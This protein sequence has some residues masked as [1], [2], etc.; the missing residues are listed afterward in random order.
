MA[1]PEDA[2]E[3]PLVAGEQTVVLHGS[4]QRMA[5][6]AAHQAP[7]HL[8][9]AFSVLLL[10]GDRTLLQK[11]AASKYHFPGLWTNACCSHPTSTDVVAEAEA[12]LMFEVGVEAS[13]EVVGSFT[14]RA[15]DPASGLVEHE[16]DTVLVGRT[17]AAGDP[18]P[19]EVSELRWVSLAELDAELASHPEAFT[20]WLT[21]VLDCV[22]ARR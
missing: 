16:H 10:D 9:E 22:R 8:H 20:P 13:L 15:T 3:P 14:Y 12:R 7:G 19:D 5:K 17:A 18:N 2:S 4:G 1:A 6:L 21:G 11:R